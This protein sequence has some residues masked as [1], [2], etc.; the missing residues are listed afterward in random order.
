MSSSI[1]N[2]LTKWSDEQLCEHEDND[3]GLYRRKS[4]EHRCHMKAWK[5]VEHQRA[6]EEVRWKAEEE[7][8]CKAEEEVQHKAKDEVWRRTEAEVRAHMEDIA[9]AQEENFEEGEMVE[10][11]KEREALKGWSKE[12]AELDES[13]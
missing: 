6:E 3:N 9:Q 11:A 4:V 12:E 5:E 1:A 7:E 2:N 10:A 13:M 8:K